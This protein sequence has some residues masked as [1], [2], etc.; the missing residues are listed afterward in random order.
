MDVEAMG[1][2]GKGVD[3][4]IGFG[5]GSPRPEIRAPKNAKALAGTSEA[6][7]FR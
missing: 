5:P 4:R 1:R 2:G 6:N 7:G 3:A